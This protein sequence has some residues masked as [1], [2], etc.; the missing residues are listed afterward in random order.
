MSVGMVNAFYQSWQWKAARAAAI[1]RAGGRCSRC[2]KR[3]NIPEHP[4]VVDHIKP[5]LENPTLA[6]SPTNLRVLCWQCHNHRHGRGHPGGIKG[7]SLNGFPIGRAHPWNKQA[8]G[9]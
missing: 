3:V 8:G 5:Y 4:A 2:A 6:L 7:T 1:Q 9:A